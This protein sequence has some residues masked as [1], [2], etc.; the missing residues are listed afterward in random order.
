M[1]RRELN[2]WLNLKIQDDHLEVWLEAFLVDRK[3]QNMAEKTLDFYS[4]KLAIFTRFCDSQAINRIFQITPDTIRRYLLWLEANGHNA[5]GVHAYYRTLK[6]FLLWWETENEPEDVRNPVCK[7]KPPKV[8]I[9][10]LEPVSLED[11]A[12]ILGTCRKGEFYGDRDRANLLALL[13]IQVLGRGNHA[14]RKSL[15]L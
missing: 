12:R 14:S 15:F 9:E 3:A 4:T 10:P 6:T 2:Q 13:E 5:G 7:V 1:S 11:I 8:G